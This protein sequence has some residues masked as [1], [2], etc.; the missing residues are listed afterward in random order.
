MMAGTVGMEFS[1]STRSRISS[2]SVGVIVGLVVPLH[3]IGRRRGQHEATIRKPW[4]LNSTPAASRPWRD[5]E[6]VGGGTLGGGG[7]HDNIHPPVLGSAINGLVACHR[8]ILRV[9]GGGEA[10][11]GEVVMGNEQPDHLRSSG[12]RKLPVG[13]KARVM[14][15]HI[16]CMAFDANVIGLSAQHLGNA[17]HRSFRGRAEL[18]RPAIEKAYLP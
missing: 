5:Q 2:R 16:V 1:L 8:M 17:L 15:G 11:G 12:G 4:G 18:C 7:E 14:N 10:C 13:C 3:L 9:T 6:G